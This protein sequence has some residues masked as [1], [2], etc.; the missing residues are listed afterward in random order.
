D[1][2]LHLLRENT[3][4]E[5]KGA[6]LVPVV[7]AIV[8][9]TIACYFLNAVFAFAIAQPGRPEVRRACADAR[10][11]LAPICAWGGGV[12]LA[13]GLVTTAV[14][15]AD[16]PW[17]ALSLGIVVAVLMVTS[18]AVPA[19]MVGPPRRPPRRDRLAASAIGGALGVVLSA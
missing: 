3:V 1:L 18:V 9:G 2:R 17:F 8:A 14:P 16:P 12:G 13:L 6:V 11:H 4:P 10:R 15:R 5:L 19:R 7:A